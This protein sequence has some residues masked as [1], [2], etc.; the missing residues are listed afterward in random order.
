M[1][2][3]LQ[4]SFYILMGT[5]VVLLVLSNRAP[6]ALSV[7]PFSGKITLPTYAA[8]ALMFAFGLMIGLLHSFW[9][10]L[11]FWREKRRLEK[12]L[13]AYQKSHDQH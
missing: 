1:I 10:G 9:R 5:L 3:I 6:L 8:L 4:L 2:K 7:F 11:A 12:Q 13:H